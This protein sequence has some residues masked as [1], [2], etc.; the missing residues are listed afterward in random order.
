MTE[1]IKKELRRL[2]V[3]LTEAQLEVVRA[4][5]E[6]PSK[7]ELVL[8][9]DDRQLSNTKQGSEEE[10]RRSLE[11]ALEKGI[12]DAT[13]NMKKLEKRL[14]LEMPRILGTA[15]NIGAKRTLKEL[16]KDSVRILREN[17]EYQ[18]GFESRLYVVWGRALDLLNI[19]I[20]ISL[21]AGASFNSQ[22]RD[23][24]SANNDY[25]FDALTRLH[26]RACQVAQEVLTLLRSGFADGAHAR[27]RSL[28]E[29]SVVSLIP[30][31]QG[32]ELAE[33]YLLHD[34]VECHKATESYQTNCEILGTKPL[35]RK[36]LR[37]R[38]VNYDKLIEQYG[39]NFGEDYGWAS[40][41]IGKAKPSLRDIE[42][43]A[44]LGHLR[45]YYKMSSHNVHASA[46]GL[47]FRL[48]LNPKSQPIL[49][50][51]PSNAGLADP[52]H[53]AAISLT[54]ITTSLLLQRT[55]IDT[56]VYCEILRTLV[57][58]IGRAFIKAHNVVSIRSFSDD[59]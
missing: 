9:F 47:F 28:H 48:G 3:R 15:I 19:L 51:G 30:S 10:L 4:Y 31:S 14:S 6:Q 58:E 17:H 11:D 27:W 50:A 46:R 1:S 44:G 53:Q 38:E 20:I 13:T 41:V 56:A 43:F 24:A 33:K 35:S 42:D 18:A 40:E 36:E 55:N 39:R 57:D 37:E 26:S 34:I 12:V 8:K 32:N 45:P 49:L 21:E 16:K 22:Y 59:K 52:G 54:Q 23:E 7:K 5:L 2:G 25:V 29:I